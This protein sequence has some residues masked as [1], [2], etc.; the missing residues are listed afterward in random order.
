MKQ[1]SQL[2]ATACLK[3]YGHL[4]IPVSLSIV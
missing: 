2:L 4:A 1:D 3:C